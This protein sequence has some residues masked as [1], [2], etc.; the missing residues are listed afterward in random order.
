MILCL[1]QEDEEISS[2]RKKKMLKKRKDIS[3]FS[4][5][6]TPISLTSI[7]TIDTREWLNAKRNKLSLREP[8]EGHLTQHDKDMDASSSSAG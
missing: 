7:D 6:V 8:Y 3:Y 1:N 2:G 4:K 5:S